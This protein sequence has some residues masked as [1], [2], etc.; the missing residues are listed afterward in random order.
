MTDFE[1]PS[2]AFSQQ[3]DIKYESSSYDGGYTFKGSNLTF[4][5]PDLQNSP[6]SIPDVTPITL[7]DDILTIP[8]M[9]YNLKSEVTSHTFQDNI[10]SKSDNIVNHVDA[11]TQSNQFRNILASAA[12]TAKNNGMSNQEVKHLV[13]AVKKSYPQFMQKN[14]DYQGKT[15]LTPL[16]DSLITNAV[17]FGADYH[18][19]NHNVD[20]NATT[21]KNLVLDVTKDVGNHFATGELISNLQSGLPIT[22]QVAIN[23]VNGTANNFS[24]LDK[25][26]VFLM[27]NG[28][29]DGQNASIAQQYCARITMPDLLPIQNTATSIG[30]TIYKSSMHK[31][32][33]QLYNFTPLHQ[34][35]YSVLG[36]INNGLFHV[37]YYVNKVPATTNNMVKSVLNPATYVVD[38]FDNNVATPVMNYFTTNDD[39]KLFIKHDPVIDPNSKSYNYSGNSMESIKT[40]DHSPK[41]CPLETVQDTDRKF[42]FDNDFSKFDGNEQIQELVKDM[43]KDFVVIPNKTGKPMFV[44]TEYLN[45]LSNKVG[46][47]PKNTTIQ[48]YYKDLQKTIIKFKIKQK[49]EYPKTTKFNNNLETICTGLSCIKGFKHFNEMNHKQKIKFVGGLALSQIPN[50]VDGVSNGVNSALGVAARLIQSGKVRFENVVGAIIENKLGIP[51]KGVENLITSL[52]KN[53]D[54]TKA[55]KQIAMDVITFLNPYAKAAMLIYSIGDMLL[56]FGHHTRQGKLGGFDVN[57]DESIKVKLLKMSVKKKVIISCPLLDIQVTNY[58]KHTKDARK[59]SEEQFL[60]EAKIKAYQVTATPFELFDPDRE[61]PKT[62]IDKNAEYIYRKMHEDKWIDVNKLTDKEI[63]I[64]ELNRYESEDDKNKR[65]DYNI[66]KKINSFYN[67]HKDE[68]IV[69]FTKE[70]INDLCNCKN[71]TEVAEKLYSL[72]FVTG[73]E[74]GKEVTLSPIVKKCLESIGIDVTKFLNYI[75]YQKHL[76]NED[77][78]EKRKKEIDAEKK[79]YIDLLIKLRNGRTQKQNNDLTKFSDDEK[80]LFDNKQGK[81]SNKEIIIYANKQVMKKHLSAETIINTGISTSINMIT[82]SIVYAD[83]ELEQMKLR[84]G[85]YILDKGGQYT[86]S[87][88][89]SYV[90]G[91]ATRHSITTLSLLEYFKEVTDETLTKWIIPNVAAGVSMT[92]SSI[93]L[94]CEGQFGNKSFGESLYDIIDNSIKVNATAIHSYLATEYV[95]WKSLTLKISAFVASI[96]FTTGIA[97]ILVPSTLLLGITRLIKD[98]LFSKKKVPVIKQDDELIKKQKME[99]KHQEVF[100]YYVNTFKKLDNPFH[101]DIVLHEMVRKGFASYPTIETVK[102]NIW[103]KGPP[104]INYGCDI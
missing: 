41:S 72:G 38:A 95:F 27:K 22:G 61:L 47:L 90:T 94:I 13:D 44:E 65:I 51:F 9:S 97:S 85:C 23:L 86:K 17:K 16:K 74:K 102:E 29:F 57:Y 82:C 88:I 98:L 84:K 33:E 66:R 96:G 54:I 10:N 46:V 53:K 34:K 93:F 68:N 11:H 20:L 30:S 73:S 92:I 58:A 40:T 15:D 36:Q 4:K 62:R 75:N 56:S 26:F 48:D 42:N 78:E 35:Q 5:S 99:L 50:L 80:I 104:S 6:I 52:V 60:K 100:N 64:F 59:A 31:T 81:Y 18:Y 87:Y 70:I 37:I 55:I 39:N 28:I 19:G 83:K 8:K 77:L 7:S 12:N 91:I 49:Q 69:T 43:V 25:Q 21:A 89:Q 103:N 45:G 79:S 1:I 71:R 76:S 24:C 14:N 63:K 67:K 101:K 2:S 32:P 3:Y